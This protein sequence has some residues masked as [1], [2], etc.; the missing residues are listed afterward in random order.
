MKYAVEMAF[1]GMIHISI[2]MNIDIGVQTT[3]TFCLSSLRGCNVGITDV[4]DL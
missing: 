2:F 3:L 4:R 1:G